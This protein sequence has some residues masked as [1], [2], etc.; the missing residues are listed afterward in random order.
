VICPGLHCPGCSG[1]QSLGVLATA[2]LG[3]VAAA[4]LVQWV[5]DRIWW[6][7]GTLAVCFA[8]AVAIS[9]WLERW[10]E[11][12][13]VRFA[14][15]NGILS[16]ADVILAASVRPAVAAPAPQVTVNIFGVPSSE[17][18]EF[19]RRAIP[20]TAGDAITEGK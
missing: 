16:R 2:V 1:K 9:V 5:A 13:G 19:I 17:Q 15:A 7:G 11:A 14:A 6:I 12:R 10:N 3:L 18:A 8:L 4:E 20:G